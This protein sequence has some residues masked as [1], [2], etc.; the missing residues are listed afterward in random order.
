MNTSGILG[1]TAPVG[2][3]ASAVGSV[4]PGGANLLPVESQRGEC[5]R[6]FHS[7]RLHKQ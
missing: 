2:P 1:V 6:E 4:A 3:A 7:P 5:I